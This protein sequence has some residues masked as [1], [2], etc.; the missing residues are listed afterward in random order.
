M[1][2]L[3][4]TDQEIETLKAYLDISL[5]ELMAAEM[6]AEARSCGCSP[7]ID[8][9]LYSALYAEFA[10]AVE[11]LALEE[12]PLS[13]ATFEDEKGGCVG[14]GLYPDLGCGRHNCPELAPRD[15]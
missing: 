7:P 1:S 4:F 15:Q 6:L 2:F 5:Y 9:K 11:E 8:K 14:K 10:A 13:S 12:D 3:L